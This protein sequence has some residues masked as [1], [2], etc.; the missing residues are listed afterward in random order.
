MANHQALFC[1]G[2]MKGTQRG[3]SGR[4]FAR[5]HKMNFFEIP[6]MADHQ[7]LFWASVV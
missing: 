5:I 4:N 6:I 3:E 1:V 2:C 7:A